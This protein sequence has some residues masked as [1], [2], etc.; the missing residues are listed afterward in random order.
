MNI[1]YLLISLKRPVSY[2]LETTIEENAAIN[3]VL[4][5]GKALQKMSTNLMAIIWELT[6]AERW[7]F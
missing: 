1:D 4:E 7:N 3:Q 5:Q 6:V 2:F